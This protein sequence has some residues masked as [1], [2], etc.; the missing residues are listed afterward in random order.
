MSIYKYITYPLC[1]I[2]E[3]K[4]LLFT[5]FNKL[6]DQITSH[7][8]GLLKKA[9]EKLTDLCKQD[10]QI[11]RTLLDDEEVECKEMIQQ[12]WRIRDDQVIYI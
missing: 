12:I 8:D 3:E 7:F 11:W 5:S 1:V 2:G 4:S 6:K 10:K 9:A